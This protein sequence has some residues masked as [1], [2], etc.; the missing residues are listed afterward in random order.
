MHVHGG[1]MFE[2]PFIQW[3][4][5][6]LPKSVL[7]QLVAAG[8]LCSDVALTF[9]IADTLFGEASLSVNWAKI[10][11][12]VLSSP[13]CPPYFTRKATES[14]RFR[15]GIAALYV[16]TVFGYCV[17]VRRTLEATLA[18]RTINL[19]VVNEALAAGGR[20]EAAIELL[21]NPPMPAGRPSD[22]CARQLHTAFEPAREALDR[23]LKAV[24]AENVESLRDLVADGRTDASE[25]VL[26]C[27]VPINR[28]AETLHFAL[29]RADINGPSSDDITNH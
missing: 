10:S 16:D 22:H 23:A 12:G 24:E 14:A 4:D 25:V 2:I 19:S 27:L 13:V 3:T 28:Y 7:D 8:H 20:I 21:A 18:G 5:E 29:Q 26:D 1:D 6:A 11:G 9:R 17:A 15:D